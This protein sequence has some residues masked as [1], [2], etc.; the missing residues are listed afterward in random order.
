M[1][2]HTLFP[3]YNVDGTSQKPLGFPMSQNRMAVPVWSYAMELLPPARIIE[4]GTNN[5]GFTTALAMHAWN[6]KIPIITYDQSPP[7]E[8]FSD[9]ARQLGV[10]FQTGDIWRLA[11]IISD[12]IKQPGTTFLLCDGGDKQRELELFA[13]A[14]KPGDVIAAHDYD[15]CHH[16]DPSIPMNDRWWQWTEVFKAHGDEVANQNGLYSW[17]QEYFDVAGWLVYRRRG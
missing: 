9:L 5:G 8:R 7:D 17:M 11:P 4:L 15:A 12:L 13:P 10:Q 2:A 1:K 14:M 6:L 3:L 16:M